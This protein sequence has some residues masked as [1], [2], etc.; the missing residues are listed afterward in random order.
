MSVMSQIVLLS[1]PLLG[2]AGVAFHL[3]SIRG[4]VAIRVPKR[5]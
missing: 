1:L 5:S 2:L 3:S 4:A